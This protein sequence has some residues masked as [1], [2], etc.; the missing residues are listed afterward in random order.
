MLYSLLY[1]LAGH[2]SGMNV[3]RYITVRT[4]LATIT[5]LLVS[6]VLGARVIEMLRRFQI[7]QT[8]RQEGPQSHA[9]KQG[10]P[11]MGGVLILTAIIV[12]TLLWMD[13]RNRFVWLVLLST[14]LHG[15]IGFYDDYRKVSGRRNQGLTAR[16]KM[17]L[18]IVVAATIGGLLYHWSFGDAPRADPQAGQSPAS[19]AA[20][21][22][23]LPTP[24]SRELHV[25]FVKEWTPDL[26]WLF[27][28][29]VIIVLVSAS[30]SVNLTDGLDGLAIGAVLVCSGTYAV[31]TYTAGHRIAADYLGIFHIPFIGEVTVFCGAMVGASL[32]FLWFNCYPAQVFMGDVGSLALGGAIGTVAVLIKQELLLLVVGGLFVIEALS[33]AIQVAYFK[34]TGGKRI[35]RMSP[36]HHHFELSGWPEPRVIVRLWILAIIFALLGL[37]TLKLR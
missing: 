27:V 24:F 2:I 23:T 32:G 5:A 31:L 15:A 26:G 8:V 3:F 10:T 20:R 16:G 14:V 7:S 1:P 6:L 28:P 33:V 21:A 11:T 4:A 9:K 36:I 37:A 34:A 12:P 13:L 18:Q 29:F 19:M 35:F 30:N 22:D 25:P 17:A